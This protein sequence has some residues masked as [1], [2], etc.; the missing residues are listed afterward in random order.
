MKGVC[1][2][3]RFF[4][5]LIVV[6]SLMTLL[7]FMDN[8]NGFTAMRNNFQLGRGSGPGANMQ[9]VQETPIHQ[10]FSKV[11]FRTSVPTS[12][13]MSKDPEKLDGDLKDDTPNNEESKKEKDFYAKK[14]ESI[15]DPIISSPFFGTFLFWLP[16]AANPKLRLRFSNFLEENFDQTIAFPVTVVSIGIAAVYWVYSDRVSDIEIATYR[17]EEA[18]RLVREEKMSQFVGNG[19]GGSSS[20]VNGGSDSDTLILEEEALSA[21]QLKDM[22]EAALREELQLRLLKPGIKVPF[23]EEDPSS[24]EEKRVAAR[25]FLGLDITEDGTL[26]PINGVH[27]E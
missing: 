12:R 2:I 23:I 17:T 24:L 6:S 7:L 21:T 10:V 15:V 16:F 20:V 27:K 18:L 4:H 14:V 3:H 8:A 11:H 13:S 26:I 9:H 22:Y 25:Q 5:R 1:C 19:G